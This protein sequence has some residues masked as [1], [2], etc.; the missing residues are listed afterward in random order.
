MSV[1][2]NVWS[3]QQ[4]RWRD[5]YARSISNQMDILT[6]LIIKKKDAPQSLEAHFDSIIMFV[7]QCLSLPD[8][9]AGYKVIELV[10]NLHPLP[11]WWGKG[12]EWLLIL[13]QI[14]QL[15]HQNSDYWHEA[16][17]YLAQG[18][19]QLVANDAEK[20]LKNSIKAK[21]VAK[22]HQIRFLLIKAEM[23][24]FDAN[25]FLGKV[26]DPLASI[27]KLEEVIQKSRSVLGDKKADVLKC[28]LLL[29]KTDV[30][31]RKGH[32]DI[33]LSLIND[34]FSISKESS[35]IEK[36]LLAELHNRRGAVY[37]SMGNYGGAIASL[38]KAIAINKQGGNYISQI[39]SNGDLGLVYWSS[40]NYFQ[41]EAVLQSS[42]RLAEDVKALWWQAIQTGN[43]GLVN[44]TR[45]KLFWANMFMKRHLELSKLTNNIPEM[46]R[47]IGNIAFLNIFLGKFKESSED[48]LLDL[49][50]SQ[51]AEY[52]IVESI[53]C[54]NLA[55]ALEG[56]GQV[57]KGLDYAHRALS[58]SERYG[59]DQA[60]IVALRSLA[61]TEKSVQQKA[62]YAE[63][64]LVLAK[65]KKRKLNEAGA[66]LT[67]AYTYENKSLHQEAD[68]ILREMG[69]SDWLHIEPF[70]D[71]IR[72]P[73]L[74]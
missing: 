1:Q 13:E 50:Y 71:N 27:V 21:A 30:L 61:E 7:R 32:Q 67:L 60:E 56:L 55:W 64:A 36:S 73:L 37:W 62:F 54:S 19:I 43:M 11:I 5:Y 18:S 57:E 40:G 74:L 45:G 23:L 14:A 51:R 72:L 65:K 42:I 28:E 29:K 2:V 63:K 10:Y 70:F 69:A 35:V 20:V 3:A 8:S 53:I 68:S 66:L 16:W 17:S 34:I 6:N 33:A 52:H 48:L 12:M 15:A 22:Q 4:E 26:N 44:F 39:D 25:T 49:E 38:E 31:R 58:I 24:A 46:Q 59:S 41:A 9:E 47:A